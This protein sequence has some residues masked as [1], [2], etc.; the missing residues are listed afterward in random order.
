MER[1]PEQPQSEASLAKVLAM[2]HA[3]PVFGALPAGILRELAEAM[4]ERLVHGG[5]TVLRE[6]EASDAIFFV[7][8][9]GLRVTRRDAMGQLLLYNQ[10]QPGQSIGELGLILQQPRAHDLTAVRDSRL[11]VLS[12][13]AYQECCIATPKNFAKF[14]CKPSMS[15]CA[16]STRQL[17][18][19]AWHRPSPCCRCSIHSTVR[20]AAPLWP[21]TCAA[22]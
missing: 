5:E 19:S 9:G 12:R 8:S 2:L 16:P 15:A 7:I 10:I 4:Q 17:Q 22:A 11:A 13:S 14:S 20:A 18:P 6:G 21:K 1:P 3:S